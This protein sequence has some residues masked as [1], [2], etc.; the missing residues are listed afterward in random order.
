MLIMPDKIDWLEKNLKERK[1]A[2]WQM[3]FRSGLNYYSDHLIGEVIERRYA[4]LEDPRRTCIEI[5]ISSR[6]YYH[7]REI[8]LNY[9]ICAAVQ[10]GQT[11]LMKQ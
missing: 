11:T 9:F 1:E 7:Y 2:I 10:A 4:L 5:A 6:T 3:I 8:A